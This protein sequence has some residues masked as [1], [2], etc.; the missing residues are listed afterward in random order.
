MTNAPTFRKTHV[1][2][3]LG[4][5]SNGDVLQDIWVDVERIDQM[6]IRTQTSLPQF[7]FENQY[8]EVNIQLKWRDDPNGDNYI[9]EDDLSA[10]AGTAR[11]HEIIKVCDPE[12]TS[13]FENPDEWVPVKTIKHIDM[14]QKGVGISQKRF[15]AESINADRKVNPRR[16]D[17]YDTNIDADAQAAFDGDPSLKA[18]V[19]P[20]ANYQRDDASKDDSQYVEH[21]VIEHLEKHI[22]AEAFSSGGHDQGVQLR[23]KNQYLIDE[24]EPA[25]LAKTG[26]DGRNPPYRLDPFQNIINC[27]FVLSVDQQWLLGIIGP[28][29]HDGTP[30]LRIPVK[31]LTKEGVSYQDAKS[32]ASGQGITVIANGCVAFGSIKTA[33]GN[34]TRSCFLRSERNDSGSVFLGEISEGGIR[35]QEAWSAPGD[36]IAVSYANDAFFVSYLAAKSST[37]SVDELIAKLAVTRDGVG[38]QAGIDPFPS[39]SGSDNHPV[40]CG[41]VVYSQKLELYVCTASDLGDDGDPNHQSYNMCWSNSKDG[42]SW[43]DHLEPRGLTGIGGQMVAYASIVTYGNGVF[44]AAIGKKNV[45]NITTQDPPYDYVL[46]SCAVAVSTSGKSWSLIGLPGAVVRSS[47]ELGD[48]EGWSSAVAFIKDKDVE[49]ANAPPPGTET[50][51]DKIE[52]YFVATGVENGGSSG[53]GVFEPTTTKMWMSTDGFG[54]SLLKEENSDAFSSFTYVELSAIAKSKKTKNVVIV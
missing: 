9:A 45:F 43:S 15:V 13:D 52:G 30:E 14:N 10:D 40:W 2:R 38:F 22:N 18:Y 5:N 23:L 53:A 20:G 12:A 46:S 35:W 25:Q 51:S 49:A 11:V 3:L 19:V 27:N 39:A 34:G 47:H 1:V 6:T 54:W 37:A 16:F 42:T 8:Q 41:N 33:D 29:P 28:D 32:G 17:H 44:V 50:T 26:P 31:A 24:S 7:N 36:V 4:T 21:E 48:R